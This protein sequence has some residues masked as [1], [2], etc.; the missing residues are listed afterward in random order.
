MNPEIHFSKVTCWTESAETAS[1]VLALTLS[2]WQEVC[3][4]VCVCVCG[5][6]V[7]TYICARVGRV[8]V[9]A[10][11]RVWEREHVLKSDFSDESHT[12]KRLLISGPLKDEREGERFSSHETIQ[13][14]PPLIKC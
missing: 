8:H 9:S 14:D 7:Y 13:T 4:C 12:C 11:A 6:T 10:S 5:H 3:V 2:G 1:S